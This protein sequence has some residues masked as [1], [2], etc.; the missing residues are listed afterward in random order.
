MLYGSTLRPAAVAHKSVSS[1]N[2]IRSHTW[3]IFNNLMIWSVFLPNLF[4]ILTVFLFLLPSVRSL[5]IYSFLCG[6]SY[7]SWKLSE[8]RTEPHLKLADLSSPRFTSPKHDWGSF[9]DGEKEAIHWEREKE[10]WRL[11]DDRFGELRVSV[12]VASSLKYTRSTTHT[13][14]AW[15]PWTAEQ[16]LSV[17]FDLRLLYLCLGVCDSFCALYSDFQLQ[18]ALCVA[19]LCTELSCDWLRAPSLHVIG[20]AD[21]QESKGIRCWIK[22]SM[23]C[24]HTHIC[25]CSL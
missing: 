15:R 5:L 22:T 12:S 16:T 7:K 1:E 17:L 20:Q 11:K 3:F 18:R 2:S 19:G 9:K 10:M 23:R 4:V 6:V 14:S 13:I 25:T 8:C 24:K 21:F